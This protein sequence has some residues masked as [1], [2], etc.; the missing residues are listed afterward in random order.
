[1]LVEPLSYGVGIP[2]VPVYMFMEPSISLLDIC[3]PLLE[4]RPLG[5]T[6]LIVAEK[7]QIICLVMCMQCKLE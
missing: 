3:V 5:R 2:F 7:Q 6:S 4:Q 1:M